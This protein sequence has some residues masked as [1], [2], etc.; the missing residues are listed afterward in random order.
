MGCCSQGWGDEGDFSLVGAAWGELERCQDSTF[1]RETL[2]Q[3]MMQQHRMHT[4]KFRL[5]SGENAFNMRTFR[6]LE[7]VAHSGC[8]ISIP[9]H[10]TFI[11]GLFQS[12]A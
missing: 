6:A 12:M 10:E 3:G 11:F 2:G 4:G 9:G 1:L 8:E 7:Q 5:N